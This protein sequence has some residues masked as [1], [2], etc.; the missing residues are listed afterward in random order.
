[1]VLFSQFNIIYF[2][3]PDSGLRSTP[4]TSALTPACPIPVRSSSSST[5]A[6]K[7][8]SGLSSD[9]NIRPPDH[10]D[11][12]S[13]MFLGTSPW[14]ATYGMMPTTHG[15]IF[16]VLHVSYLCFPTPQVKLL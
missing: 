11:F 2:L 9:S 12:T 6:P 14:L 16:L 8:W 5:L 4:C 1:M 13:S 7:V 10:V 3:C 15:N